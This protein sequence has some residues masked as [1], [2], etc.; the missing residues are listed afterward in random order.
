[1]AT[2]SLGHKLSRLLRPQVDPVFWGHKLTQ[3]F[4]A[5]SCP[6]G[7]PWRWW[8]LNSWVLLWCTWEVTGTHSYKSLVCCSRTSP[9]CTITP[10]PNCQSGLWLITAQVVDHPSYSHDLAPSD[11]HLTGLFKKHLP[12]KQFAAGADVKRA[13]TSWLQTLH[14]DVFYAGVQ[15]LVPRWDKWSNVNGNYVEV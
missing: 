10:D 3:S 14:T 2:V 6:C 15:T 12:I 5:T 9:F 1:M 11:L 7:F 8:H 13:V 4:E